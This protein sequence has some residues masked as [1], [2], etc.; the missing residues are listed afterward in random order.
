MTDLNAEKLSAIRN[1]LRTKHLTHSFQENDPFP[2]V[3]AKLNQDDFGVVIDFQAEFV[4][5]MNLHL[6]QRQVSSESGSTKITMAQEPI[7]SIFEFGVL[8]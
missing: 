8:T 2:S 3:L 4:H 6:I 1:L 5:F 7:D